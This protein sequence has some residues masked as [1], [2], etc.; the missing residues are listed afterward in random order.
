MFMLGVFRPSYSG[1]RRTDFTLQA[2]VG[3]ILLLG[4]TKPHNA[5]T[6]CHQVNSGCIWDAFSGWPGKM[7]ER[8]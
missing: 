4:R 5:A 3:L 6:R 8:R 2:P 7:I 1:Q